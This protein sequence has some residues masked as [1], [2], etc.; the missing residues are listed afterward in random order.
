[1]LRN[2]SLR[3]RRAWAAALAFPFVF[4]T[5]LAAASRTASPVAATAADSL[6]P[7]HA[8]G[9]R[10]ENF[11]IVDGRIYRGAQPGRDD[12]RALAALGVTMVI[13]LRLDAKATSRM[14]L[15]MLRD[16]KAL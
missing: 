15:I 3:P 1:M 11:G 2:S 12:Y 10:L 6:G 16:L 14:L 5:A 9:I 13:D 7:L 8:A 4:G